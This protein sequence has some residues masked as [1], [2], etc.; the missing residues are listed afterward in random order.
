MDEYE[1]ANQWL[2]KRLNLP[3]A[4]TSFEI[5]RDFEARQRAHAFFSARVAEGH[6]LERLRGISDAYSRGEIGLADARTRLKKFLRG[7]GK[8]DGTNGLRN[9]A[10]TA[11]LNLILEQ[12]TR[13][14]AAVGRWQVSMDA[15]IRDRWPC[16][17]Y[18]GSTAQNPR[19]THARFASF[20]A[21]F[22][23]AFSC[24]LCSFSSYFCALLRAFFSLRVSFRF[25]LRTPLRR[26]SASYPV[27][28][29][30]SCN[31]PLTGFLFI[32]GSGSSSS[33]SSSSSQ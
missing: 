11:R 9:L 15:E 26:S 30:S 13:M 14:A 23:S 8:D 24:S 12:N 17:R 2:Q 25:G 31:L 19:D 5:S 16:W 3:T 22:L 6:I 20:F 18:I 28:I 27:T 32:A 7:E 21:F 1:A 29:G 4:K 33:P 10:S